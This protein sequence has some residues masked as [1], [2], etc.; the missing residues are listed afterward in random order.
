MNEFM[1]EFQLIK[2]I[3]YNYKN[4]II[5]E[6]NNIKDGDRYT[7][8]QI[9]LTKKVHTADELVTVDKDKKIIVNDVKNSFIET[10][11][12]RGG[13]TKEQIHFAE[14]TAKIVFGNLINDVVTGIPAPC[15]FGKSSISLEILKKLI[16]LIK[17]GITTNGLILVTDRLDSLRD[18]QEN[19]KEMSLDG[20]TYI[21]EGWNENICKNKKVKQAESKMCSPSKCPY[22]YKCKVYE[23][24]KEQ[25]KYPI[26][27]ITNAR[28]RECGDSIKRYSSWE[29]GERTVLLIDERPDILDTVKV[30]KKLLNEIS[31]EIS[32]CEYETVEEK[33]ELENLWN[34]I[35]N[36]IEN[37]MQ[38]LRKKYK[39]F[40][41]SNINNEIICKNDTRFMELWDK[42]MKFNFK[43]ELEHIHKVL[44]LGGFYVYEKNREF[45]TTIGSKNLKEMYSDTFKTVIFDGTALY[46]PLYLKMYKNESIKFLD[47]QNTR[48]YENLFIDAYVQHKMTKTIFRDK[49]YYIK[50]C[51]DFIKSKMR[52]G[53]NKKGYVVTYQTIAVQ[54]AELLGDTS[55]IPMNDGVCYYF[56]N[57]KGKNSMKDCNVMFQVGWDTMPDYEY[58]IQWLSVCITDWEKNIELCSDLKYA[59]EISEQ[60][61]IKDRKFEQ[62]GE[63]K[64]S[65]SYSCYEFGFTLLNQFKLFMIV[66]NFYQEVHRIKLR[67]YTCTEEK[68]QVNLFAQKRIVFD[69]IEQLFPKCHM[70]RIKKEL[71]HFKEGKIKGR[72]TKDG[73]MTAPQKFLNWY[74]NWDGKK[75]S[76]TEIKKKCKISNNQWKDLKRK[77]DIKSI[78]SELKNFKEGRVYYYSR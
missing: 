6:K 61:E 71:S 27:L 67:N 3:D 24:Q 76:V 73:K 42:Y 33:T 49:N 65:S 54:L 45:I 1:R 60:L 64:Y 29:N 16:Q 23:Q 9:E 36:T 30:N 41:T 43:R 68:I 77:S 11:K 63:D 22:F 5:D 40:I 44:T 13:A 53:F 7:Y 78:L 48:L 19:L 59:E 10:F 55:R 50:A 58:A 72:K 12:N 37:K 35:Q 2:N 28:L 66:T 17:D 14:E 51:A 70:E 18:T 38:K 32:K 69:M 39:R 56:G 75:I 34:E 20:Y 46:D 62:Y 4:Y 74:D 21:L 25:N 15:G 47:I 26:L 57:T 52:N 8:N 31:T